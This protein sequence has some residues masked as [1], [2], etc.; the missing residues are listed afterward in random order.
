[1]SKE[2][3]I[4]G[5]PLVKRSVANQKLKIKVQNYNAKFKTFLLTALGFKL[6]GLSYPLP[7]ALCHL[8][9]GPWSLPTVSSIIGRTCAFG[10]K[11]PPKKMPPNVLTCGMTRTK[12]FFKISDFCF[13]VPAQTIEI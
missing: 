1:M 7:P 8:T 5:T 10:T 3:L 13:Q 2:T 4:V 11:K 12:N 9:T 6:S